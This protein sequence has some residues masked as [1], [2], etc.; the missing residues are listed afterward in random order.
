[1]L[2]WR[3]K[4][5]CCGAHCPGQRIS[6]ASCSSAWPQPG[7]HACQLSDEVDY[8]NVILLTQPIALT[9]AQP[10]VETTTTC[11]LHMARRVVCESPIDARKSREMNRRHILDRELGDRKLSYHFATH[12]AG[13]SNRK[14]P[15]M[16]TT[17]HPSVRS[18]QRARCSL[19][20][21]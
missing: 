4:V 10:G 15:G 14:P 13:N 12:E 21:Q 2:I 19:P 5:K 3:T 18:R 20:H 16:T 11:N 1:M 8:L 6:G 7:A 17:R 9:W